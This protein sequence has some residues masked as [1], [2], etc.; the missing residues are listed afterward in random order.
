MLTSACLVCNSGFKS[1]TLVKINWPLP[2][3][4]F[5]EPIEWKQT[6]KLCQWTL[7]LKIPTGRGRHLVINQLSCGVEL[8]TTANNIS[9]TGKLGGGGVNLLALPVFLPSIISFLFTQNNGRG[10][11]PRSATELVVRTGLES[12]T[13]GISLAMDYWEQHQ[14]VVRTEIQVQQPNHSATMPLTHKHV[15]IHTN[16]STVNLR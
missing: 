11:S 1:F 2:H 9:Y 8:R 7:W 13:S 3:C 4:T 14:S 15:N 12:S 6:T 5:S 16:K 10:G